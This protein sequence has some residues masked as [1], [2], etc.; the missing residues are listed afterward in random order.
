MCR[1]ISA[2][3]KRTP[4]S[5]A[6]AAGNGSHPHLP[7]DVGKGMQLLGTQ[8]LGAF[9]QLLV[10]K[11]VHTGEEGVAAFAERDAHGSPEIGQIGEK[12]LHIGRMLSKCVQPVLQSKERFLCHD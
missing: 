2:S 6:N 12:D 9:I 11:F 4:G 10:K 3:L 8:R 1:L 7:D 5:A